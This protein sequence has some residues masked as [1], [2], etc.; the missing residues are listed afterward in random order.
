MEKAKN[1]LRWAGPENGWFQVD[2]KYFRASNKL[3]EQGF[4][5]GLLDYFDGKTQQYALDALKRFVESESFVDEKIRERIVVGICYT[6][7]DNSDEQLLEWA[8]MVNPKKVVDRL[9]KELKKRA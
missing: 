8:K 5:C 2:D 4:D 3:L 6:G 9:K 7:G 1:D